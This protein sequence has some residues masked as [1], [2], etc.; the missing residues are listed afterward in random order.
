MKRYLLSFF[1]VLFSTLGANAMSYEEAREQAY[2]LT[3]KMAYELN[4]N[5]QQ[6][7]DAYEINLDYLLSLNS[8]ADLYGT[9][10]DY[11]NAD[12]RYILYDWQWD[13]FM[14]A[15][16][17]Y[18]PVWWYNGGW[19][20]PIYNYYVRGYYWYDRPRIFWDYRGAHGRAHFI[21]RS[22]YANRR[23]MWNGG[24]RGAE[25]SLI[26]HPNGRNGGRYGG[27]QMRG[28]QGRGTVNQG[29][30]T[31]N[32]NQG[33]GTVNRSGRGSGTYNRG[34]VNQGRGTT[35]QGR[36][37][38][39]SGQQMRRYEGSTRTPQRGTVNSS[40]TRSR[41]TVGNTSGYRS[42]SRSGSSSVSS[43]STSSSRN[44]SSS[45][46]RGS[47]SSSR[48]GSFSSGGSSRGGGSF[49]SGGASRGGGSSMG[50]G[51]RGGRR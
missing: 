31:T 47:V 19:L 23:P 28:G 33:R 51:S 48:G 46:S 35:S 40:S 39:N 21:H 10:L 42:S 6:Y 17:F 2:Y 13:V 45:S 44:I 50:G 26:G 9:Y 20:F 11:R 18:R 14:A 8:E 1:V 22:Y 30:G 49:S 34:T 32:M 5:E 25:R 41:S 15:D 38:V 27:A 12:L 37:T 7:N 24:F 36:G 3:D 43:R 16:Y 4:L 29:R